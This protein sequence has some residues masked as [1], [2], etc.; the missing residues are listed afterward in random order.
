MRRFRLFS[1]S[2]PVVVAAAFFTVFFMRQ[3]FGKSVEE[4][5][6]G[7]YDGKSVPS[8]GVVRD[9]SDMAGLSSMIPGISEKVREVDFGNNMI[10]YLVTG[11]TEEDLEGYEIYK[12]RQGEGY[13]SVLCRRRSSSVSGPSCQVAL[14]A[15]MDGEGIFCF[16]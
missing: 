11:I 6:S 15:N 2:M 14:S 13:F 9:R 5:W 3:P 12:V 1:L 7:G 8:W 10:L 16:R 4:L